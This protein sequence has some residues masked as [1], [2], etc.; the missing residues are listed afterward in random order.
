MTQRIRSTLVIVSLLIGSSGSTAQPRTCAEAAKALDAAL[1]H[2]VTVN[3]FGPQQANRATELALELFRE[4]MGSLVEADDL[5][6]AKRM[7]ERQSAEDRASR[8]AIG[9]CDEFH[10][11]ARLR[12]QVIQRIDRQLDDAFA[13]ASDA[14]VQPPQTALAAKAQELVGQFIQ[15]QEQFA[16]HEVAMQFTR[17]IMSRQRIALAESNRDWAAIA[18]ARA[19]VGALDRR[20]RFLLP[21]EQRRLKEL[22]GGQVG[23]FGIR[24]A[25]DGL[26][27][28]GH[29]LAKPPAGTPG[30]QPGNLEEGLVLLAID[31]ESTVGKPPRELSDGLGQL[32]SR[33]ELEVAR[34]K[35]RAL[36]NQ[37]TVVLERG[38]V[39]DEEHRLV[40]EQEV[41]AGVRVGTVKLPGFFAGASE[42]LGRELELFAETGV[43][44]VVL[45]LRGNPGGLVQEALNVLDVLC[46]D[47]SFVDF[48][49]S[50]GVKRGWSGGLPQ[51]W[52]GALVVAVDGE[53]AS[54]AEIV[55]GTLQA[56]GRALVAGNRTWG[57]GSVQSGTSRGLPWGEVLVTK[58]RYFLE[59][60]RSPQCVGIEPDV[61]LPAAV[62]PTERECTAPDALPEPLPLEESQSHAP[63]WRKTEVDA[64]HGLLGVAA[65]YATQTESAP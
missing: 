21:R 6:V 49:H 52:S 10:E 59:N 32:G 2:H 17:E 50:K 43:T 24:F 15:H 38:L 55:A 48:Q 28:W 11:L 35:N 56:K 45:D 41:F 61:V 40:V 53:T 31:G 29:L 23:L 9:E 58:S 1:A 39:V 3:E 51:A 27:P 64:A 33:V 19:T 8:W 63:P 36:V 42:L 16:P 65:S 4:D 60:G 7:L 37:R 54:A 30:A 14:G 12:G 13:S 34:I 5:D 44:V 26:T 22:V 25:R 18:M 57:K 62:T 46:P 47:S 20:T